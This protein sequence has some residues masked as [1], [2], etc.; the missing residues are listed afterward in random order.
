MVLLGLGA[1]GPQV[2][3]ALAVGATIGVYTVNDSNAVRDH[4]TTYAFALFVTIGL[5]T[6]LLGVSMGRSAAMRASLRT[7]LRRHAVTGT[8]SAAS[9]VLVLVAVRRAPV[10]YVSALR[11][12]SVLIAAFLGT[13][14]LAESHARRRTVAAAVILTGL[15]LL[16]TTA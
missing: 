11:E 13:R 1:H 7:D 10:G 14:Y 15:V 5:S 6:T 4:G 16:I 8:M 2:A 12:S 3:M 9:Y